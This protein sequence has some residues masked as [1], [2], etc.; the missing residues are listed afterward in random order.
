MPDLYVRIGESAPIPFTIEEDGLPLHIGSSSNF[1]A[2]ECNFLASNGEKITFSGAKIQIL[3]DNTDPNKGKVEVLPDGTE[4]KLTH[5]KY[6]VYFWLTDSS[7]KKHGVPNR[8][9]IYVG[10]LLS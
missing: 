5:K 6:D 9:Q 3:D 10:I 4:W 2:V 1:T 8:R 7:S